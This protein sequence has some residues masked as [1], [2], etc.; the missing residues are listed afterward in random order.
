MDF[1]LQTG[2]YCVHNG[3]VLGSRA[4]LQIFCSAIMRRLAPVAL[5]NQHSFVVEAVGHF[6]PEGDQPRPFGDGFRRTLVR[7]S[8]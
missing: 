6:T 5:R 3:R 4:I 8:Q 7:V 2:S 1:Y